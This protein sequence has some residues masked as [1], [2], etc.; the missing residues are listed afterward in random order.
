MSNSPGSGMA[1]GSRPFQ[2]LGE[3]TPDRVKLTLV[4]QS[5]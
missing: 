4:Y 2:L 1:K 5:T 3:I